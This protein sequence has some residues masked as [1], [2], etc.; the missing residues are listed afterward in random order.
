MRKPYEVRKSKKKGEGL[1]S[2]KKFEIGDCVAD[3]TG[4]IVPGDQSSSYS[5]QV[6]INEFV[7]WP[8]KPENKNTPRWKEDYCNH[9]CDPN[10]I[11]RRTN[12]KIWLEAIRKIEIDDEISFNYNSTEF[13]LIESKSDFKC[14]CGSSN[15][16][17]FVK[18]FKYLSQKERE[19]IKPI[20]LPYLKLICKQE[21]PH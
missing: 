21:K 13:D 4:P 8:Q 15:C 20:A 1:F 18:G 6:G 9:S 11:V 12:R 16:V 19:K 17:G 2:L 14:E 7:Y 5:L 3:M 10:C